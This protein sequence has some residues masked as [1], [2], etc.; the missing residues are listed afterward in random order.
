VTRKL[1]NYQ[2]ILLGLSIINQIID[3]V[4]V[5]GAQAYHA[6]KLW[7][8]TPPNYDKRNYQETVWRMLRSKQIKKEV[9]NGRPVLKLSSAGRKLINK[10]FNLLQLQKQP[11]DKKWRLVIF[12]LPKSKKTQRDLLR[13]KL[14]S[15]GFGQWQR[16]IYISPYDFNQDIVDFLK[17]KKLY[18]HAWAITA[19]HE[20][21]PPAANLAN[22]IWHLEKVNYAYKKLLERFKKSKKP[23]KENYNNYINLLLK[24]PMLPKKLLPQPWWADEIKRCLKN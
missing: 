21:L 14:K 19:K 3:D 1:R 2:R 23:K 24:D 15:L 17:F 9:V 16:S 18:G 6:R 22:D 5:S 10:E 13:L 12:D 20:Y 4:V 8:W 7:F 11:W